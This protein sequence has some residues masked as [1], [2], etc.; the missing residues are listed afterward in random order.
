MIDIIKSN[1]DLCTGCNRCVRECPMETANITYQDEAGNIKVK[2]DNKKCIACGRCVSA[3]K[4]GARFFTDDTERFFK[5]LSEGIPISLI[6]AP[7]IKTNMPEYKKLFTYLKKLGVNKI[8][9][10]S[11]GA[12]I[13]IWAH[14]KY[15]EKNGTTPIIT[16]PCPVIVTYCEIY[17]HDLLKKL[18]PIQSPMACAS[19]YMKEYRGI[20]DRIAS[21]S[22]CIAKTNEFDET[23]LTHYN[24]TF[25]KL[26]EYLKKNEI[27]IPDEETEF[28]HD[29]GSLGSLFPKPGGLKENIE[30]FIGN[31]F[32]I[33]TAEDFNIYEKLNQYS[34]TPEHYLPEIYDV[35][36]CKEG[37]NLGSANAYEKN[38]FEI[39][40]TMNDLKKKSNEEHKRKYYE[41]LYKKYDE[42]FTLS[43][44]MRKYK[45]VPLS[46]P[47]IKENDIS[48][49]FELLGK[50]DDEKQ[51]VDCGA[52]GSTKCSNM[53][54]KIALGVNIPENCI[55]K[56]K[57]DAKNEHENNMK[58]HAQIVEMEKMREADDRIRA[59]I[60]STPL[61]TH[62]WDK[63]LKI[64][65][66]NE[67]TVK[68][69][70]IANKQ[71]YIDNFNDF[72]PEYQA[73][74][75][76]S[77][78]AA[79]EYIQKTFEKGYLRIDWTH[80]T[81]EKELVPSEMTL[82]RVDNKGDCFVTAYTRD[83]REQKQMIKEIEEA[84]ITTSA[85]F[86]ANPQINVLFDNSFKVI[87]CNPAALQFIGFDTKEEL[88]SGFFERITKSIPLFQPNGQPSVPLSERLI[89]AAQEGSVKFDTEM[90]LGDIKRNLNVEFKRIPYENSFAIVGYIY[91]V[92]EIQKR[93][94]ELARAQEKNEL[95][96]IKLNA[97]VKAAK[98][99]LWDVVIF[100]NDSVN[101]KNI[102]S[103]S[104]EFRYMLGYS[105]E[106][107]FPNEYESWNDRLH[108]DD[109]EEAHSAIIEH[110]LDKTGKTPYDVEYRLLRKNGEYAYFHATG[111]TIRDK[112]GNAIRIVGALIDITERKK[113]EEKIILREKMTNT[114][115][116][117]SIIFLRQDEKTFEEKMSEGVQIIATMM[118]LDSMSVWRNYENE[119]ELYT[120]QIY[121]WT[122]K[123]GGTIDPKKELQN[124]PLKNLTPNWKELLV[125][126]KILNGPVKNMENAPEKLEYYG[127]ISA[128]LTPLYF[129][130][131]YWGFVIFEDRHNERYFD[132]VEFMRSAAFLFANTVM[133][134]E[135]ES[136]LKEALH[137]AT[138]ASRAK[139]EFLANMSHEI[140]TPMNAIFGMTTIA[141]TTEEVERKNYAIGKI[142]D[143]SNHLLGVIND[144]LDM[145]KIEAEKFE[146]SPVSFEFEKMLQKVVNVIN[147]RVDERRQKLFVKV[148]KGI[149]DVLEGD[150]QR[151]SQV[152]TNLLSNAVKFTQEEG[153]IRLNTE[154]I[155]E[156]D[157]MCRLE[158]SVA[159]TGIG[160]TSEQKER[161]FQSFE[162]AEA[163]TSRKFGGT[164]LGLAISKKIVKLMD[165]DIW[166]DSEPGKGSKFIFTVVLKRG[167]GEKKRMFDESV[168]WK[169]IR[170]FAVYD[171]PEIREFFMTVSENLG[172]ECTVAASGE[173]A[174]EMLK[175][176]DNYNIYFLDWKLPG[177]NGIEFARK[178]QEKGFQNSIVTMFSSTDWNLI[179]SEA[180]SAGVAKFLQK[181]LFPSMIV[182]M[183]N[184]SLGIKMTTEQDDNSQYSDDF[185]GCSIMLAEDVEINREIVLTLLEPTNLN[186]ECAENGVQAVK[187]FE[188]DPEKYDMIFMDVQ[189]PEM[190]GYEATKLI[191]GIKNPRSK[192]IPIIAMTAN[193]FR[194]DIEKCLDVGMNGHIGKPINLD[195]VLTQ[196]RLYL[197]KN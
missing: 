137:N 54:R 89:T 9:D 98:I 168:N 13:C 99:G 15:L 11:L 8:Y 25:S 90:I 160:I 120:S 28:D 112:N 153:T 56:S 79:V 14:L 115:N 1:N 65:D 158:I 128:L 157:G 142:K 121:Q 53:A 59:V 167:S 47:Q 64:V 107:D 82:V 118:D 6:A 88:L 76:L 148:G 163:G 146:L 51:H 173:E 125:G 43:H 109:K 187:M 151:L 22:P 40:K 32:H 57:D 100:E 116:K 119:N 62:I 4:H 162:Q 131:E 39:D 132:E 44:F 179:E 58:A 145:S 136:K 156:E 87:D 182:D 46:F 30:Y 71:E 24:I 113:T 74:G 111:E 61:C 106:T 77:K 186:V 31:K 60:D 196:L 123:D 166:V 181:P 84:Q 155:G 169:N 41:S 133:R 105:N 52:C 143:A 37:C 18:S 164:G 144:I 104:D 174:A 130:N 127:I 110:F 188:D 19:I 147:F 103:W 72:S 49:A 16:Q 3:C 126:E 141:E 80:L 7:S 97:V 5:D 154:L 67:A 35:L 26:L 12:D 108:P 91:D 193:V 192:T 92:T 150:D 85:M 138:V 42:V 195:D 93:E 175:S 10:V 17:R 2:I 185:T 180:L 170:I 191:R 21:L 20:Q 165:G 29:E 73:D 102:Y 27:E 63:N 189:M 33:S 75:R 139:S 122:G 78:E 81:F 149:P 183:I 171:E 152:I 95:Q 48:R 172:I 177:M 96:L 23:K 36:N 55:V 134:S 197:P 38:I 178:I 129:N 86:E 114:L 66:C 140:R 50:T 124:I 159:D 45:S 69:F 161:L 68:L 117:M 83:L 184:E 176:D 70:K 101:P 194:E 34:K 190:D 94:T 135:M